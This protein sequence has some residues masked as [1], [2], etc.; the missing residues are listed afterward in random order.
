MKGFKK[1][2]A[3]LKDF[4]PDVVVGF[5]G[6]VSVPLIAA[7]LFLKKPVVL[8]EANA[9][10]GTANRLMARGAKV[11]AISF[12]EAADYFYGRKDLVLT[13]MPIRPDI[14]KGTRK[15]AAEA[16]GIDPDV[17]TILIFGG[18]L[19]AHAVNQATVDALPRFS[20]LCPLQIL[21]LTGMIDFD[22]IQT[23]VKTLGNLDEQIV[24]RC[25]A[26]LDRMNLAYAVS[27]LIVA[28]AGAS[29]IAEITAREI[30]PILIPYPFAT[31]DHQ[32]KNARSLEQR[33]A[34]RIILNRDLS[35]ERLFDEV[36][37]LVSDQQALAEMKSNLRQIGHPDAAKKLARLVLSVAPQKD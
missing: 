4:Q 31:A 2:L 21:H 5:G 22:Q 34:A 17:K 32:E 18:S 37:K 15:E 9:H 36:D 29:T 16:L 30:P 6:F 11:V 19:G 25:L 35:G 33:G 7:A 14:L 27:D 28:R 24:Y 20:S 12:P 26:Y 23:Q 10:P 8:H 3:I 13:G 1:A